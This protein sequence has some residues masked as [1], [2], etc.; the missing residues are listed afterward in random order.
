MDT[1]IDWACVRDEVTGYLQDL[2]RIDTTNPPGNETLAAGYIANVLER[3]GFR[4]VQTESAPGRGNVTTR[5]A[6]GGQEPLL[7]LGHTDVVAV[8]AS[9]WTHEPFSGALVDGFVWGRGALDTK[10]MVAVELMVMLLLKRTGARP[11][12]DVYLCCH[13][14]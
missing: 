8:D 2:I 10:N 9:R 3:E 5:L 12:C 7:L 4:T 14:R 11:D 1:S 13:G 6:G